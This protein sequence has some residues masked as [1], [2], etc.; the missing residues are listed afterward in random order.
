[1]RLA[2]IVVLTALFFSSES[3][4]ETR[5]AAAR[6]VQ[7]VT[8]YCERNREDCERARVYAGDMGEKAGKLAAGLLTAAWEQVKDLPKEAAVRGFARRADHGTL[9]DRD[10]EPGWRGP[11]EQAGMMPE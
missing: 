5:E 2:A 7:W 9:T 11:P 4:K 3:L 1:M 6:H 10:L 8:T